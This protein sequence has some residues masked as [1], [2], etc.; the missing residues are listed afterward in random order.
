MT[1]KFTVDGV[2][3]TKGTFHKIMKTVFLTFIIACF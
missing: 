1:K 2:L 3:R